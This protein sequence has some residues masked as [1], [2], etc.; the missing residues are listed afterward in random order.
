MRLNY[1]R[2]AAKDGAPYDSFPFAAEG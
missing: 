1:L 2:D